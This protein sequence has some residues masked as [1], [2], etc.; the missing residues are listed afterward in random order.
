[1]AVITA[2]LQAGNVAP[3][4]QFLVDVDGSAWC[5]PSAAGQPCY[6]SRSAAS[7]GSISGVV[8]ASSALSVYGN[9]QSDLR[10]YRDATSTVTSQQNTQSLWPSNSSKRRR[11]LRP[12]KATMSKSSVSSGPSPCPNTSTTGVYDANALAGAG[13]TTESQSGL[14]AQQYTKVA[15]T[16][17]V[18]PSRPHP[19][20]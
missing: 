10:A 16:D 17:M 6:E 4:G 7:G 14:A 19:P 13:G 8:A 11:R 3:P 12:H 5:A 15:A 20:R 2:A 9:V 18:D 1:M